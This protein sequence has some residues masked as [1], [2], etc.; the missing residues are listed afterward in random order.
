VIVRIKVALG[1]AKRLND[2]TVADAAL[3]RA[4]VCIEREDRQE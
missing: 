3:K 2:I 1:Y 4:V